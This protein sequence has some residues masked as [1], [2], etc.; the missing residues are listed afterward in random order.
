MTFKYVSDVSQERGVRCSLVLLCLEQETMCCNQ[1]DLAYLP[2]E[3]DFLILTVDKSDHLFTGEE[4]L[5]RVVLQ[6]IRQ[7][8]IK[9]DENI[10]DHTLKRALVHGLWVLLVLQKT[11]PLFQVIRYRFRT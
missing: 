10:V 3:K 5:L 8:L 2:L 7:T 6:N 1:E 11:E 9:D 4:I